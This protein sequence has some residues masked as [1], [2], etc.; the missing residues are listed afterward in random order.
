LHFKHL[1]AIFSLF[2]LHFK[3]LGKK[4]GDPFFCRKGGAS[5]YFDLV[6]PMVRFMINSGF[7]ERNLRMTKQLPPR[8]RTWTSR[9]WPRTRRRSV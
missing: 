9:L 6:R 1:G 5:L 8:S 7:H 3:A 2:F 4:G